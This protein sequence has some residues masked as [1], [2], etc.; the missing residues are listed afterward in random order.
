MTAH[1]LNTDEL[2]VYPTPFVRK[3][4][5]YPYNVYTHMRSA[6]RRWK[7]DPREH[8]WHS[9]EPTVV[10]TCPEWECTKCGLKVYGTGPAPTF[11]EHE[12]CDERVVRQLH[13]L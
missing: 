2:A 5:G 4:I 11:I 3:Y 9:V 7:N 12:D 1:R 6:W 13:D 10:S 8:D